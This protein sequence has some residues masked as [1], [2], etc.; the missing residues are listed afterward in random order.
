[1]RRFLDQLW[2]PLPWML[3][4][5]LILQLSLSKQNDAIV[6]FFLLLFKASV[7]FSQETRT[8]NILAILKSNLMVKGHALR[9]GSWTM[10]DASELVPGD[11]IRV[12]MGDIV[13]ADILVSEGSVEVD[14]VEVTPGGRISSG[15]IVRR[16]EVT[17]VVES[18]GKRSL[19][20]NTSTFAGIRKIVKILVTMS[21]LAALVIYA[22]DKHQMEIL[23]FALVLLVASLPFSLPA[24]VTLMSAAA[25]QQ[26][27]EKGILVTRLSAIEEAAGIDLLC[28]DKSGTLTLNRLE[29][30]GLEAAAPFSQKELLQ[31][32]ALASQQ[33]S[34]DPID[35]A[36][37]SLAQ[38]EG[39]L[40]MER[41]LKFIP[42]D[43]KLKRSEAFAKM[44]EHKILHIVKGAPAVVAALVKEGKE[45]Q[46]KADILSE[47]G[48]RVL[49]AAVG[50]EEEL[51]FAG[52]LLFADPARPEAKGVISDL[53]SMGVA[54]KM[55][56]GDTP[57]T[58]E[59]VATE[60]GI[61]PRLCRREEIL[62]GH[63]RECES[64]PEV[65][66]E[67]KFHLVA[68]LQKSGYVVGITG[69]KV[70]DAPALRQSDLG[71]AVADT[72]DAAKASAGIALP[73]PG[74]S[75]L[76]DIIK[77]S[78]TA[79]I[80]M[81]SYTQNN[82]IQSIHIALFLSLGLLLFH[83]FVITPRLIMLLIFAN[84]RIGMSLASDRVAIPPMP[85]RW[86]IRNALG[87]FAIGLCWVLFSFG[88]FYVG[89]D[90]FSLALPDLQTLVFLLM[91][92][93]KLATVYLVRNNFWQVRP[94]KLLL[95]STI[96]LLAV[97]SLLASL[98]ILMESLKP[99][100][101]VLLALS[102]FAF[103]LL[104]IKVRQVFG[105]QR[106]DWRAFPDLP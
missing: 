79:F 55:V 96:A 40:Q 27:A 86:N 21:L 54:V 65:F 20:A 11:L 78:R 97:V 84:D 12:R 72:S 64:F 28:C 67:D 73:Q 2:G 13:P 3:G 7:S 94:G 49:C 100:I 38:Q 50:T 62:T 104:L 77:A 85:C 34:Q 52:F 91:V 103:M 66:P 10:L 25:A 60:V 35:V 19:F 89:R 46:D 22:T 102:V 98:G 9:N 93:S 17:G 56:T 14:R 31:Y 43:P 68:A 1:M 90:Y 29:L 5:I 44:D 82:I 81:R 53:T 33:G 18:A 30:L 63:L 88:V 59:A 74:I 95:G 26:L 42:F 6:T 32:A 41:R 105:F 47:G 71:I 24:S 23:L 4:V 51:Q 69:D 70:D 76:V 37:L 45:I 75:S 99:G 83:V 8:E 80:R 15:S 61:G 16:G 106:H 57:A 101:I 58:A 92:F 48:Y 36:I 39:V 87:S